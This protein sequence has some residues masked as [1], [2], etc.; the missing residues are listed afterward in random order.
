MQFLVD[1]LSL[2]SGS[3]DPIFADPDPEEAKI[4]R[5][6]IISTESSNMFSHNTKCSISELGK[7]DVH[8]F[9]KIPELRFQTCDLSEEVCVNENLDWD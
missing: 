5:I 7:F 8:K 4:F 2:G 3:V 1:I 6:P 9:S